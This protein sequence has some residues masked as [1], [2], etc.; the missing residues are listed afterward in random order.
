[1]LVIIR[2]TMQCVYQ[3]PSQLRSK[4]KCRI[5][6]F[7][8]LANAPDIPVL[9]GNRMASLAQMIRE[10]SSFKIHRDAWARM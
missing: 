3:F 9:T 4:L 5:H 10:D 1:M 2:P 6:T 7:F 8:L